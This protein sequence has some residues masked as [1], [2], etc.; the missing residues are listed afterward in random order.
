MAGF[1]ITVPILPFMAR[2]LGTS[3]I[4]VSLL[5]S[6]FALAQ[7]L[8]GPVWGSL[9]DRYGRRRILAAGLAGYSLSF[10]LA[11]LSTTLPALIGSRALGGLLSASVFPASQAFIADK[12][13]REDRGP[14]M[15]VMGAWINLGFLLG[16]VIG[17]ALS[18]LGYRTPMF[19]A[20]AVTAATSAFAA[21]GL[22]EPGEAVSKVEATGERAAAPRGWPSPA[23][24]RAALTSPT[25]PY[26]WMTFAVSFS[27]AGLTAL[28]AYF[29]I[30]RLGGASLD[31][32][33]I[34][35]ALGLVGFIAQ[36]L[37]VGRLIRRFGEHRLAIGG[38]LVSVLGLVALVP[39]TTLAPA[40]AAVM[41][42]GLGVS[43]L[44]PSLTS[45][46]SCLTPLPQG[47]TM[48]VQSSLDSLGRMAGPIA[49]GWVY[50]YG[51]TLPFLTSATILALFGTWLTRT[52]V[53]SPDARGSRRPVARPLPRP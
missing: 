41:V 20:G 6:L 44:R 52:G 46:V 24:I 36:S 50:G 29:V 25:S 2:E 18:P 43:L 40:V 53:P 15:A 3:P 19:V 32:A 30:D 27:M 45:S 11:G 28:L 49:C 21:L 51:V 31:A 9:S 37:L 34:F 13:S 14:A 12:T 47:L 38:T 10:F 8:S 7:F 23:D 35:T 42:A 5:I 17:G 4:G 16:P 22:R 26:L 39:A 48:G 33:T 1:G